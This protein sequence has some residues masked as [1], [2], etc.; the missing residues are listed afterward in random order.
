MGQKAL[1]STTPIEPVPVLFATESETVAWLLQTEFK[2]YCE[3]ETTCRFTLNH[4]NVNTRH[5][6]SI[7]ECLMSHAWANQQHIFILLDGLILRDR[8]STLEQLRLAMAEPALSRRFDREPAQ[9]LLRC[10]DYDPIS[11]D[12]VQ[13]YDAARH[14]QRWMLVARLCAKKMLPRDMATYMQLH[15]AS[16]MEP[17][18]DFFLCH[19][20]RVRL[21]PYRVANLTVRHSGDCAD[22]PALID[23]V[24]SQKKVSRKKL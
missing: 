12:L 16:Q 20:R 18:L 17:G 21:V 6:T 15:Y 7:R 8:R 11:T 14:L 22:I 23:K 3:A 13:A 4:V 5:D 9:L 19:G 10:C 1:K 24:L 2:L